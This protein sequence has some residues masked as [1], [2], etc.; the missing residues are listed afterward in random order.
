MK[1]YTKTG[2][3][4][5]TGLIGGTR[6]SKADIRLEAYGT[7]DELNAQIGLLAAEE[8]KPEH[9]MFLQ[10][11]QNLLFTVGSNL[12]TDTTKTEYRAASVMKA[13]YIETIEKEIDRIDLLL[14]PLTNF[15]L[16]GGSRKS[17]LCHVCRTISRRAERRIIELNRTYEIENKIIIFVNRLS[18]YFFVLS[19]L[20]LME[21]QKQEISWKQPK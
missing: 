19:R 7:V 18:D 15:I 8:L 14:P 1:I 5:Q 10:N 12:A 16:P 11:I 3:T 20:M 17:A 6:V 9:R 13:E 4:G 21:E 2:D